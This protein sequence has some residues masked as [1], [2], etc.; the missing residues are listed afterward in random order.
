MDT[1]KENIKKCERATEIQKEWVPGMGRVAD[2]A[3]TSSTVVFLRTIN[4]EYISHYKEMDYKKENPS[5]LAMHEDVLGLITIGYS[6]HKINHAA[7]DSSYPALDIVVE[8][9]NAHLVTQEQWLPK[10]WCVWLPHQDQL[11]EMVFKDVGL[12]SICSAI[13]QFSKSEDGAGIT[14]FGT[15]EQLWLAFVMEKK[16]NK[17]WNGEEWKLG[18]E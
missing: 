6:A 2:M 18:P 9:N 15:M 8:I 14:I 13:E 7:I 10:E 1:S 16:Y 17:T 11:Q 3:Y 4:K 5:W 12:Q